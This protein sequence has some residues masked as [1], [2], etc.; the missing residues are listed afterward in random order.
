MADGTLQIYDYEP[1][2]RII[3][4]TPAK[5]SCRGSYNTL[6]QVRAGQ[7]TSIYVADMMP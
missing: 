6:G 2:H 7:S 5:M 1:R 3:V 4:I